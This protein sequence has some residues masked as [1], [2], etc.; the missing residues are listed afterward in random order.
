MKEKR[1]LTFYC[2]GERFIKI[3]CDR[4]KK[5]NKDIRLYDSNIMSEIRQMT[6]EDLK[7]VLTN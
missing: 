5:K 4:I 7:Q 1:E 2:N 6:A 3:I